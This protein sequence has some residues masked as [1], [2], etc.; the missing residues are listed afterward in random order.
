[1]QGH[2]F[3]ATSLDGFIA[4][5][6]GSLDWLPGANGTTVDEDHGFNT[7]MGGVDALVMGS[8]TYEKV[9]DLGF[10]PYGDKPVIVL[11]TRPGELQ[12]PPSG[13][14]EFLSGDPLAVAAQLDQ[15]GLHHVYL[16]GGQTIRRFLAAGLVRRLIVTRIPILLGEGI[17]LFGELGRDVPLRHVATRSFPSGLV[18]SEYEVTGG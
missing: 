7:F 12:P 5:T 18:Q 6:N 9:L 15:R 14:V 1:M 8:R 10:W 13:A 11:T 17:P 3:I 2:V 16:D 4:R